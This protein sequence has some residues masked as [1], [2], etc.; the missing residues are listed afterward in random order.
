MP[1][2]VPESFLGRFLEIAVATGDIRASFD[3]YARLGLVSVTTGDIVPHPYGVLASGDLVLALHA[4][5]R[6]SPC[7]TFVRPDVARVATALESRGIPLAP[8]RLDS[9]SFN[10]IGFADPAG[11]ACRVVEARTFSPPPR[12]PAGLC[13][14]FDALSLP[15]ADR[16]ALIEFWLAV[17]FA[18]NGAGEAD[19]DAGDAAGDEDLR[20]SLGA[21]RLALH[22]PGVSPAGMLLFRSAD[23]AATKAALTQHGV[24]VGRL[25][26]GMAAPHLLV[27][28]PEGTQLVIL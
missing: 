13:G 1:A 23:V 12:A 5:E 20:L 19:D 22:A 11:N 16:D 7:I 26:R 27:T 18:A 8:R 21:L 9:D 28:A 6:D 24:P 15:A 3:F 2:P 4:A 17:G 14:T 25:R 10:E